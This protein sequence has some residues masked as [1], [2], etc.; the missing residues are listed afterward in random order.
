MRLTLRTLLAYLDDVLEPAQAKEIGQKIKESSVAT[1]LVERIREVM[2]RRRLS[3]P[4]VEDSSSQGNANTI[5]EYLD[6]ILTPDQVTQLERV[7][8]ES[9]VNLAEVAATHQI[10]SLVLGEPISVPTS[11]KERMYALGGTKIPSDSKVG[12]PTYEPPATKAERV[13]S[14]GGSGVI[15]KGA[16]A[17][18]EASAGTAV[19]EAPGEEHVG[20]PD[21][22][23]PVPFWKRAALPLAL[24]SLLCLWG[25]AT[26]G[27]PQMWNRLVGIKNP[28]P[29]SLVGKKDS[30]KS[31]PAESERT[32]SEEPTEEVATLT[33]ETPDEE[34]PADETTKEPVEVAANSPEKKEAS[35]SI[36]KLGDDD[37][38]P[39]KDLPTPADETA[40]PTEQKPAETEPKSGEPESPEATPAEETPGAEQEVASVTPSKKPDEQ[41]VLEEPKK[42]APAEAARMAT[43]AEYRSTDGILLYR[44]P[45]QKS[46]RVKP[47]HGALR[48]GELIAV[49]EPFDAI[50]TMTNTRHSL[51]AQSK[52]VLQWVGPKDQADGGFVIQRGQVAF[53]P[54]QPGTLPK[55]EEIE[56]PLTVTV[57]V[58]LDSWL[59]QVLTPETVSGIE[60]IP[61][62]PQKYEEGVKPDRATVQ[63]CVAKGSVKYVRLDGPVTDDQ[64]RIVDGP[65]TLTLPSKYHEQEAVDSLMS[66][67]TGEQLPGGQKIQGGKLTL[68]YEW[69]N[70]QRSSMAKNR[71]AKQFS[72]EFE[73]A[74]DQPIEP[75]MLQVSKDLTALMAKMATSTLGLVGDY[76]D[77]IQ[78]MQQTSHSDVRREA[79]EELRIWLA[80]APENGRLLLDGLNSRFSPTEATT[81]YQLLW[82][83]DITAGTNPETSK[84]LVELLDD[85]NDSVRELAFL[86][87]RRLTN[88]RQNDYRPNSPESIR[89][90]GVNNWRRYLEKNQGMLV[91][92]PKPAGGD[93]A[94]QGTEQPVDPL[95]VEIKKPRE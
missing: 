32:Q 79:I 66:E 15:P 82:G 58:G 9:D 40:E 54:R 16:L 19:A 72:K 18:V 24:V 69:L 48:D 17:P 45:D 46:W 34:M 86:H 90:T 94:S 10:L 65:I 51:S 92:P 4:D 41:P 22:I 95:K 13:A 7:C 27:D 74:T 37:E 91:P 29:T 47:H 44:M 85:P 33:D 84:M 2:R 61:Y 78:I 83:Y 21:E 43:P 49:P 67:L 5:A 8:L 14:L 63:L 93:A 70:D 20:V 26:F 38:M 71:N 75:L 6:N 76:R 12:I 87:I 55:E 42:E 59:I 11:T 23:R 53:L 28:D 62:Q 64:F 88:N 60:V 89:K 52:T 35:S 56:T 31:S 73:L 80:E 77:L 25:Y 30:T 81:L 50:L 3:A 1:D 39:D 68:G 57:T 36:P